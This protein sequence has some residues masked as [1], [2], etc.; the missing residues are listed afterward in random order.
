MIMERKTENKL[1]SNMVYQMVYQSLVVFYPLLTMPVVSKAFG[2]EIL[3]TYSYTYSIAY[4]FSLVSI[5]GIQTYGSRLVAFDRDDTS[6]LKKS[7]W[8]L[9]SIQLLCTSIVFGIYIGY[10]FLGTNNYPMTWLL[11]GTTILMAMTDISWFFTGIEQFKT[12]VLRNTIIKI[13]SLIA[14]LILV[15]SASDLNVYILIMNGSN[16]MGQLIIWPSALKIVGTPR[17]SLS[18]MKFHMPQVIKLFVPIMATNAYVLIDK[19]MLGLMRPMAEVGYYENSDRLIKMPVGLACAVSA[20]I[21]PRAAYY[22]SH[23]QSEKII[24]YLQKTFKVVLLF[25]VPIAVGLAG[26]APEL[27]PWYL[28]EDFIPC[29]GYIQ[30]LSPVIIIVVI[31]NIL[32]MQYYVPKQKDAEYTR[33]V[34]L[35]AII[36]F[37]INFL[38][39]R[40]YG[41][42]GIIVGTLIGEGVGM[43]YLVFKSKDEVPYA[44]VMKVFGTYMLAASLMGVVIRIVGRKLGASIYTN[45]IQ[46]LIGAVIY[47]IVLFLIGKVT[48]YKRK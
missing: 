46:V 47:F 14:I 37:I 21:L 27:V 40:T 9:Y 41:G 10:V 24:E 33:C 45:A 22:V 23:G 13:I 12:M 44:N 43:F 28:G 39:V 32:R 35:V 7:F 36:N 11:Q 26:V 6:K 34:V 5:L 3:G 17:F 4:Y 42:Y 29:I 20:V 25:A 30:M 48:N 31:G 38:T 15:R 1:A 2:S 19:T 8:Q 18:N 16:I